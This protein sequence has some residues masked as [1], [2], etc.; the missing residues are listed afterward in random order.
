MSRISKVGFEVEGG[1]DGKPGV[2]PFPDEDSRLIADHSLNGQSLGTDIRLAAVHI[3]EAISKP[4]VYRQRDS[5]P[6]H[7]LTSWESWLL[8]HWPNAEPPNRT[9]RT[10]GFHIHISL[11]QDFDYT[12]LTSKDFLL[13]LRDAVMELGKQKKLPKKHPFWARMYGANNFCSPFFDAGAQMGLA[14]KGGSTRYGWLNFPAKIHGTVEFRALPTFRDGPVAVEFADTFF[15]T[16]DTWL[17]S[18]AG[19]PFPCRTASFRG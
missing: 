4:M 3:G 9:N 19:E 11:K 1:W 18:Q 14:S 2:S 15:R 8:A 7:P 17:E 6:D 5:N 13:H 16:V 12:L 10:C